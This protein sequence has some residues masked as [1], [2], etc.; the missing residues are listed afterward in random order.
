MASDREILEKK[1][2]LNE[3]VDI[4]DGTIIPAL[5]AGA[6][7]DSESSANNG[8]VFILPKLVSGNLL[9]P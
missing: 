5:P 3:S 1:Y 8:A 6:S 7:S 2:W 4:P 9:D